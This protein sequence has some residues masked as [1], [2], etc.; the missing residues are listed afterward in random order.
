MFDCRTQ[1]L[2]PDSKIACVSSLASLVL[3]EITIS[4]PLL[5]RVMC[6]GCQPGRAPRTI[7]IAVKRSCWRSKRLQTL[8]LEK[9]RA[10]AEL[11]RSTE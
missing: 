4:C 8:A 6:L 5:L 7:A 11:S 9:H 10:I 3:P 2:T 1:P